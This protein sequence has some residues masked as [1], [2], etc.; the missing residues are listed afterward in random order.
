MIVIA[1]HIYR[2]GEA[3][4]RL[5]N[6]PLIEVS[7]RDDLRR[8]LPEATVLAISRFWRNDLLDLAPRLRVIQS[9]SAGTDQFDVGQISRR[10]IRLAS[11]QTANEVAVAEHAIALMLSL[12]RQL[13][14]ARDHQTLRAW[15]DLPPV[16]ASREVEVSGKVLAVVGFGRIGRRVARIAKALG[17]N[18]IGVQRRPPACDEHADV[19]VSSDK[20]NGALEH[21]DIVLLTC[22]YTA[23]TEKLIGRAQFSV[24]KSSAL[25]LNVARGR[26]VDQDA[27]IS[28]LEAGEL[29]GAALDCFVEEPLAP[30]SPLWSFP[31]V[32]ITPHSAGNTQRYEAN[33]A[34]I[35]AENVTRLESGALKLL[36]QVNFLEQ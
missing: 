24:M 26:I 13:H 6:D 9:I 12:T 20:L 8:Y 16:R 32:I 25:L 10:G 17:M 15:R 7:T 22:P 35:L 21:A 30:S 3:Y 14:Y 4:G 31:N 33:V 29:A 34:A 23:E 5:R 36:N 1:H 28:A 27:L 11:A 19:L 18:V 2:L